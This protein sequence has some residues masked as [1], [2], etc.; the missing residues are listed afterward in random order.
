MTLRQRSRKERPQ[1]HLKS[2]PQRLKERNIF[3]NTVTKTLAPTAAFTFTSAYT[4]VSGLTPAVTASKSSR[5]Q[6]VWSVTWDVTPVRN[7]THVR[8]A[9]RLLLT[10]VHWS[11]TSEHTQERDL[12][13]VIC[14]TRPLLNPVLFVFIKR[15]Y[16]RTSFLTEKT[17]KW[18][19]FLLLDFLYV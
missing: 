7:R 3:V 18:A 4:P 6:A 5:T 13:C 2:L 11:R 1:T 15:L 19:T 16:M 17:A 10:A 8:H 14:V 12:S 9:P